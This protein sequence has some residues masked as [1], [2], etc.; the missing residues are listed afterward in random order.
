MDLFNRILDLAGDS[1]N[2][3]PRHRQT[4][5]KPHPRAVRNCPTGRIRRYK[6]S[7]KTRYTPVLTNRDP[8]GRTV[9]RRAIPRRRSTHTMY[10]RTTNR[11]ASPNDSHKAGPKG[12]RRHHPILAYLSHKRLHYKCA[13]L[14]DLPSKAHCHM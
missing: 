6:A 13:R 7:N 11:V 1:T 3:L 2:P 8:N 12:N 4:N 14:P 5:T 10:V 9:E